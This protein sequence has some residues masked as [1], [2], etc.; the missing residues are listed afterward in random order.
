MRHH[1]VDGLFGSITVGVEGH[2]LEGEVG[3]EYIVEVIDHFSKCVAAYAL[4]N[5]E[6]TIV[7]LLWSR[8]GF[9]VL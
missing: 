5:R 3:N 4:P 6:A 9:V 8:T 2:F 1:N 7:V